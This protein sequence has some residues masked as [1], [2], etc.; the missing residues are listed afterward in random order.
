MHTRK[1]I[2][3]GQFYPAQQQQ[4]LFEIEQDLG[5]SRLRTILPQQIDGGIV[6]HAGW[7]F[8]GQLALMVFSAIKQ[9]H[10]QVD[11]FVLFGAAHGYPSVI[12]ALFDS[13]QWQTPMGTIEVDEELANEVLATAAAIADHLA[14]RHEHS[15][16]VQVPFIQYLFEDSKI[17]PIITPPAKESIRLG[18]AI[19]EIIKNKKDK[20]IVCIGSAD[21]THY[22]PSYGFEPMG[23]G[24][25][26]IQW[27]HE[28][29]DK[30]VIDL[31]VQLEP[32]NILQTAE[33]HYNTCGAGAIAATVAAVKTIGKTA[34]RVIGQT[35]SSQIMQEKLDRS[36]D[37]SVGYAGIIF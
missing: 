12:P 13:G 17:L 31:A 32:E 28:T 34:G 8:S 22:G 26:A 6:P 15:I 5:Q 25:K 9:Q 14:H 21:L 11:T 37:D 2:V 20:K 24:P 3:A 7:F 10:E 35:N 27:A 18:T 1:P 4:C 23:T 30:I 19:G 36:G 33:E 16:E 29:N